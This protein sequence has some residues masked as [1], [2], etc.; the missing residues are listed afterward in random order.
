LTLWR[1]TTRLR[2]QYLSPVTKI[3]LQFAVALIGML[4]LVAVT[5]AAVVGQVFFQGPTDL[6]FALVT[7]L[8]GITSMAATYLFRNGNSA[9]G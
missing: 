4:G 7:A 1:L 3:Q 9:G 5:V 6:T 2:P 8:T